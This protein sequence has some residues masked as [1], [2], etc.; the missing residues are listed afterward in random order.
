MISRSTVSFEAETE[1]PKNLYYGCFI[2]LVTAFYFIAL[3][4]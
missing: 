3:F 4:S 1:S 2:I